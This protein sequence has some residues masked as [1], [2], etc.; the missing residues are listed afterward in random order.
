MK[1][2][3]GVV[4]TVCSFAVGLVTPFLYPT[5][6]AAEYVYLLPGPRESG[7]EQPHA[8][9]KS[10]NE[11]GRIDLKGCSVEGSDEIPSLSES[12]VATTGHDDAIEQI[13]NLRNLLA[14][15]ARLIG[16]IRQSKNS[17][18]NERLKTQLAELETRNAD[19]KIKNEKLMEGTTGLR[20]AHG[21]SVFPEITRAL[22][23]CKKS[24]ELL[25]KSADAA[26]AGRVNA[27]EKYYKQARR[28]MTRAEREISKRV[29]FF[30][31]GR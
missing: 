21:D 25:D 30:D 9:S 18:K 23:K 17:R 13:E 26:V 10:S 5:K 11:S 4:L 31:S 6:P 3:I 16:V 1:T 29:T 2:G 20:N 24:M 15:D 28:E 14:A 27:S 8:E 19:L 12:L 7:D 22:K